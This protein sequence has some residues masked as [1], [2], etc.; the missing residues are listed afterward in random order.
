MTLK[1]D[2]EKLVKAFEHMIDHVTES[3]HKAEEAI[4]PG[5]E[6]MIHN[7]QEVARDIYALTQEESDDLAKALKR[8]LS[9]ANKTLNQQ[10]KEL[11]DWLSFDLA[12]V[13]DRFIDLVA[14]AADKVWLDFRAFESEDHQGSIYHSGEICSPGTLSCNHCGKR[15]HLSKSGHIPPCAGCQHTEF[16]RVIG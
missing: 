1:V 9:K 2:N 7:A 16:Y 12:V 14:K 4:G 6:E 5:L 11:K 8:D 13:E 10:K 3:I 15:L